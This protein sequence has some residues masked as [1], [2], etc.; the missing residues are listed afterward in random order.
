MIPRIIHEKCLEFNVLYFQ[1]LYD[2]IS[3][4]FPSK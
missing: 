2:Y 4:S 3:I 1:T